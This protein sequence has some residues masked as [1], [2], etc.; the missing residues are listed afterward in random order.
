MIL[1]GMSDSDPWK[2][3][4][5]PDSGKARK[6]AEL[7]AAMSEGELQNL[8]GVAGS[9]TD[10]ARDTLQAEVARRGLDIELRDSPVAPENV[11]LRDLVKLRQF[12]ELHEALLARSILESAGVECFLGD[13]N[14]IRMDW[15]WSNLLGGVKLLVRREDA[16]VAEKLLAGGDPATPDAAE[17]KSSQSYCPGCRSAGVPFNELNKPAATAAV[18]SATLALPPI[19]LS[20]RRWKCPSCGREWSQSSEA[21][22]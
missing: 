4:N 16:D 13:D 8:A 14:L 15:F 11:E 9:L 12:G 19:P 3:G 20:R 5:S 18:G 22:S 21:A 6:L 1:P 17:G 7:Y 2:R 10:V